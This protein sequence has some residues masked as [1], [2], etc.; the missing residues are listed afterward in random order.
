MKTRSAKYREIKSKELEAQVAQNL[1]EEQKAE[2]FTMLERP[3]APDRPTKPNRGKIL[4]LGF[5]S[6]RS[7]A[8]SDPAYLAEGLD[9]NIRGRRTLERLLGEPCSA[10]YR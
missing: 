9:S 3:I 2:R 4:L 6:C 10:R 1:E 5:R 8:A 7:P